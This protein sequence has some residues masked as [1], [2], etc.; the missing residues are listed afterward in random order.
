MELTCTD[1]CHNFFHSNCWKEQRKEVLDIE[2]NWRVVKDE[3][4]LAYCERLEKYQTHV[5]GCCQWEVSVFH[6]RL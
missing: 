2:G 4:R 6:Q 3:V 1:K 5:P